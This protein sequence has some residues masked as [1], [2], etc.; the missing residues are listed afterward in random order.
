MEKEPRDY[1]YPFKQ[2]AQGYYLNLRTEQGVFELRPYDTYIFKPTSP[3]H[4]DIRAWEKAH[5]ERYKPETIEEILDR[6]E[7]SV[8]F[9]KIIELALKNF[10][11]GWEYYS[12]EWGEDYGSEGNM[13]R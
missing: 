4:G 12:P 9:D 10:D 13:D 3:E 11:E 6:N 5:G 7:P 2:D 8:V 1:E